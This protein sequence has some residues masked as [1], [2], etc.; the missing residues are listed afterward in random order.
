MV[1]VALVEIGLKVLFPS[2][3]P[4]GVT[5]VILV[6]LFFGA[7][8]LFALGILGEYIGR[9]F[10]EVKQRPLYVRRGIIKDGAVRLVSGT[11]AAPAAPPV[12]SV[13]RTT[14]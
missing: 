7:I 13:G 14:P 12:G 8:N 11:T 3:A 5:T 1:L 6:V 9:I 10:E 2:I 4:K